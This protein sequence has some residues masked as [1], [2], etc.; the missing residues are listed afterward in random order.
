MKGKWG[1]GEWGK[2]RFGSK[3]KTGKQHSERKTAQQVENGC[4]GRAEFVYMDLYAQVGMIGVFWET[5][6]R[7]LS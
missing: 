3:R 1:V 5:D 7:M 2:T 6:G 4:L